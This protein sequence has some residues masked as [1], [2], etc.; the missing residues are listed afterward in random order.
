MYSFLL[1]VL[2]QTFPRSLF[3]PQILSTPKQQP[4]ITILKVNCIHNKK[5]IKLGHSN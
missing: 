1:S 4:H 3:F 2:V 5:N